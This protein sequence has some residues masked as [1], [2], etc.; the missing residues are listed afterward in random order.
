MP[1]KKCDH[2]INN[3]IVYS[4]VFGFSSN[5][6]LNKWSKPE[7]GVRSEHLL[8]VDDELCKEQFGVRGG[9]MAPNLFMEIIHPG[10]HRCWRHALNNMSKYK[11][12]I[13][14][15]SLKKLYYKK[16]VKYMK[17]GW[18]PIGD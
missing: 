11:Q 1:G 15:G 9:C 18:T 4:R 12:M 14:T 2:D 6:D 17:A 10:W 3:E 16:I 13:K 8:C 5:Y 7:L